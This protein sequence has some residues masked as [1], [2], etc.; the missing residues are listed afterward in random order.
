VSVKNK[1]FVARVDNRDVSFVSYDL[2]DNTVL[3]IKNSN[4]LASSTPVWEAFHVMVELYY[5]VAVFE[6]E[7]RNLLAYDSNEGMVLEIPIVHPSNVSRNERGA[8]VITYAR[9]TVPFSVPASVF[10]N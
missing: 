8:L 4:F 9:K 7:R 1:R 10:Q 3:R 2:L 6:S 5:R